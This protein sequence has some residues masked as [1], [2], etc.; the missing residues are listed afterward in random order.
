[1]HIFSLHTCFKIKSSNKVRW[2]SGKAGEPKGGAWWVWRSVLA[3]AW[4]VEAAETAI[5]R[6]E[7]ITK[8][9]T[10]KGTLCSSTLPSNKPFYLTTSLVFSRLNALIHYHHDLYVISITCLALSS[11]KFWTE[12]LIHTTN[13]RKSTKSWTGTTYRCGDFYI[14]SCSSKYTV[15][16]SS[17]MPLTTNLCKNTHPAPQTRQN[18]PDLC[19]NF[20]STSDLQQNLWN[21]WNF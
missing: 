1:M 18:I 7:S 6:E 16:K 8:P 12:A 5:L 9:S 20:Q 17:E 13:C 10:R 2:C 4:T 3:T 14:C 11:S 19:K 21:V 15:V